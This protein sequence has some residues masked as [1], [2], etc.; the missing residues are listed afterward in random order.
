V[1]YGQAE[2]LVDFELRTRRASPG[3]GRGYM[4]VYASREASIS[5]V[6]VHYIFCTSR[7]ER[8]SIRQ[9]Y[10][11]FTETAVVKYEPEKWFI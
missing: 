3:L 11:P 7:E 4:L 2:C 1:Y 10:T 8:D 5:R 6:V 9:E